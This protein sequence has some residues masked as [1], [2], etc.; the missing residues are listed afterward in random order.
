MDIIQ[1]GMKETQRNAT[2]MKYGSTLPVLE[3]Y[4]IN[5]WYTASKIRP[6]TLNVKGGYK[7]TTVGGEID[8]T[9]DCDLAINSTFPKLYTSTL[10]TLDWKEKQLVCGLILLPLH[11]KNKNVIILRI[12]WSMLAI[13]KPRKVVEQ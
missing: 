8:A 4:L 10:I 3:P 7:T 12:M 5:N 13:M 6:N 9:F 11:G 1:I 2:L